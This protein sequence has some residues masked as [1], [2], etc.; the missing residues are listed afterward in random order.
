MYC[1]LLVRPNSV[2]RCLNCKYGHRLKNLT[3]WQSIRQLAAIK[4]CQK[5]Y[6]QFNSTMLFPIPVKIST[7]WKSY[8]VH[9]HTCRN[10]LSEWSV[11]TKG[12]FSLLLLPISCTEINNWLHASPR[13]FN[14]HLIVL[15]Y[16]CI[17]LWC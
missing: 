7:T 9:I 16:W 17:P 1:L 15:I 4:I 8:S 6:Y 11:V 12:Q 3:T 14:S 2:N 10:L 13:S 5:R